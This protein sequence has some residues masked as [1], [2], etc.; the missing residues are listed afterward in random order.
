MLGVLLLRMLPHL[1]MTMKLTTKIMHLALMWH[2]ESPELVGNLCVLRGGMHVSIKHS[3]TLYYLGYTKPFILS[4]T[5]SYGLQQLVDLTSK[6]GG[7]QPR[8]DS[9]AQGHDLPA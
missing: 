6:L 5:D 2:Q 7:N 4:L 1:V 3:T 9:I 8:P